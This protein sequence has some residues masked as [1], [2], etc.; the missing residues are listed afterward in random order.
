MPDSRSP[1]PNPQHPA[2]ASA[3]D[4]GIAGGAAAPAALAPPPRD[5]R[6]LLQRYGAGLP[7]YLDAER[8]RQLA[9]CAR[10]WPRLFV[11]AKPAG[12]T[13]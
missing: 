5:V 13:A 11:R 9:Q 2:P 12:N 7:C 1:C 4:P 3:A 6:A 10:R 8:Q